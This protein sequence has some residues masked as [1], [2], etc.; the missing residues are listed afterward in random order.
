MASHESKILIRFPIS[1]VVF[2]LLQFVSFD[3]EEIEVRANHRSLDIWRGK[4][5]L[6]S[7]LDEDE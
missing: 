3:R 4:L 2:I 5:V 6:F 7:E 1:L